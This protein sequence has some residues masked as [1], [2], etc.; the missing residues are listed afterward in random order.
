MR[1]C[2]DSSVIKS[3]RFRD[4]PLSSQMLFIHLIL[5]ADNY[6]FLN[7]AKSTA[8]NIGASSE[9]LD[10]LIQKGFL[11]HFP[12]EVFCI[13]HWFMM[14]RQDKRLVPTFGEFELVKIKNNKMS[15]SQIYII[16][17]SYF[18]TSYSILVLYFLFLYNI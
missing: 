2:I 5:E 10:N 9:D 13:T 7:N 18:Y 17:H 12:S 4:M 14:N 16:F 1:R 11:L 6:G 3:D 8:E 15:K